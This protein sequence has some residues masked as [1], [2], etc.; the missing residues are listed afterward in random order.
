ML[1][2]MLLVTKTLFSALQGR[3]HLALENLALR[4]QLAI[5]KQSVKRPRLSALDRLF[6]VLFSKH[7][8]DWRAMLHIIHPDTVIR[9]HRKD[10]R[11]FWTKKS[12]R[13]RVGRPRINSELQKLIRKMQSENVGSGAPRIHGELLKLGITVSQAT[14]LNYLKSSRKLPS[15]TWRTFLINHADCFGGD[16]FFHG[17]HCDLSRALRIYRSN[18]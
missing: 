16:G 3:R 1:Q 10:F 7:F 4:Q 6:W 12:W 17:T 2:Y 9:W 13:R 5:F 14:V 11:Y 8:G 18:P 15:Q